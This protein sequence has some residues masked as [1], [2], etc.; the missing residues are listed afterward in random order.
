[1]LIPKTKVPDLKFPLTN[2][3]EFDLPTVQL[4]SGH[5]NP[6]VLLKV[7]TKLDPEKLVAVIG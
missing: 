6:S 5:K 4:M 2:N 7:Y 1:M 3:S